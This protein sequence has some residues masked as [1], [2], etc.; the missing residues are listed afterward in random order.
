[1]QWNTLARAL[2]TPDQHLIASGDTHDWANYRFW[3]TLQELTRF[4]ADILCLEEIDFYEE[5]KPYLHSLGYNNRV[6]HF[7]V[8]IFKFQQ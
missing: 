5:V 8:L 6:F 3:R 7:H 2:Y 4:K 1:M